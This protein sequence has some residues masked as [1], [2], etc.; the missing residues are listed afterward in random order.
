MGRR[1]RCLADCV[2][3]LHYRQDN[4]DMKTP[5]PADPHPVV[6]ELAERR[7]TQGIKLDDLAEKSG[8]S[9]SHLMKMECGHRSPSFF[10]LNAWANTLGVELTI[11][12]Q[13]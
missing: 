9:V 12:D 11:K 5:R 2:G 1:S 7:R 6:K 3:V 13:E 4:P 10:A 8:Y